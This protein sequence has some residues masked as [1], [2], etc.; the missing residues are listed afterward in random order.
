M[1]E[2]IGSA[3]SPAWMNF[4][5]GVAIYLPRVLAMLSLVLAGWVIAMVV[6]F[7]V[8]TLL[9]WLK[10]NRLAQRFGIGELFR[11][12]DLPPADTIL[13]S[14]VFW[15]VW[16]GFL[17]S[18][19][20]ALGM[21]GMETLASDFMYFIP[22]LLVALAIVAIGLVTANF[23]WRAT[24][25]AAVNA[26]VPSARLLAGAVRFLIVILA[27]AMALDQIA[28]ARSVVLTAFA[29]AFGAVML[30]MA[31]AFG[32][33]GSQVARRMLEQH[34]PESKPRDSDTVS[35]L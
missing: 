17:L 26:Q 4:M 19:V 5:D 27:V 8:R 21:R 34:F 31:I 2:T 23:A 29:I 32:I 10:F 18:G 33:G 12:T 13:A 35:H 11:K 3:L 25:L 7:L 20:G 16:V 28:V 6:A 22:R 30:G 14:V 1:L 15:L 24:V 9:G